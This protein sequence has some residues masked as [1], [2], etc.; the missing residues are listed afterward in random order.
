[1]KL[2]FKF[3]GKAG[4]KHRKRVLDALSQGGAR[5]V[6]RLFP[7]ETDKELAALYV[8]DFEGEG[9]G[10]QLLELLKGSKDIEFAEGEVR[11]K[12]IK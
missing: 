5:A 6:R 1:M 4:E 7:N 2:Q 8:V 9:A 12:L 3:K 11:R 10:Q